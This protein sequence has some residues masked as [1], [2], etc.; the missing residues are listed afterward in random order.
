MKDLHD[1]FKAI[2]LAHDLPESFLSNIEFTGIPDQAVY[3]SFRLGVA[4]SISIGLSGLSAA[5][6]HFL[7]TGIAQKVTVDARHAVLSCHSQAYYTTD[8][9]VPSGDTWDTIAGLYRTK[10]NGWVR[11]HTN[12]PH[13]RVGVLS[14]LGIPDT[15]SSPATKETVRATIARWDA[16]ELEDACAERGM[17]VFRMRSLEEWDASP[18]GRAV[19]ALPIVDVRPIAATGTAPGTGSGSSAG[20]NPNPTDIHI[21]GLHQT[22][23]PTRPL[24]GLRILDLSRVLAGPVAGRTLAAHGA[25]VLL[26]TSPSFPD[27]P[28]LDVETSLGK[29]TVQIDV[30]Q[31]DG[32]QTLTALARDADVFLQA[33]RPGALQGKGF[34]VG[35]VVRMKMDAAGVGKGKQEG[36]LSGGIVYA[37]LSAWGWDGPW[38]GRRG[39]DSLVQ[40]ATGFNYD[41]GAVFMYYHNQNNAQ[42]IERDGIVP[43]PLPMQALDHAAGYFLAFGVHVALIKALRSGGSHEVRVSLAGVGRWVRSLGRLRLDSFTEK[44]PV[45]PKNAEDE[46]IK[47]LSIEWCERRGTSL[48]IRSVSSS[49]SGTPETVQ[50]PRRKMTALRHAA[51]LAK[52]PVREGILAADAGGNGDWGA[53]MRLDADAAVWVE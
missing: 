8:G 31:S 42:G 26:V 46:E 24:S 22:P 44:L 36:I 10:E 5:Y 18:Q 2:W 3:S 4:A 39:F 51:V 34:G 23:N 41:E 29:R 47:R 12:F 33:Y 11:I 45:L 13:H 43:R 21:R 30:E 9:T 6:L 20:D 7:R 1:E 17:C 38:A 40:T 15:P 52:T 35:D 19:A 32:R 14:I 16:Q 48:P 50:K 25:Q 28:L 53:P 27:L 37:S 49:V